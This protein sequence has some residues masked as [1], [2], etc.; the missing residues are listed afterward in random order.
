[1]HYAKD[2]TLDSNSF[3]QLFLLRDKMNNRLQ[4]SMIYF[5]LVYKQ[6]IKDF[7]ATNM[8]KIKQQKTYE[9]KLKITYY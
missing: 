3:I 7:L 9:T 6:Y 5:N 1:M 8:I 2:T 4:N